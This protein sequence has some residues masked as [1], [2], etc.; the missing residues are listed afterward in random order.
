[1]LLSE[2]SGYL[3]ASSALP[4]TC[5]NLELEQSTH[6]SEVCKHS[7]AA[8][9]VTAGARRAG[10]VSKSLVEAHGVM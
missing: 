3:K 7:S 6:E 5:L 4:S 10:C 1:M 2:T 8:R 9:R